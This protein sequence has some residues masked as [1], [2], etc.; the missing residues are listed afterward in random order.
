[1]ITKT[2]IY[3]ADSFWLDLITLSGPEINRLHGVFMK[4][5][6]LF[7][8]LLLPAASCL[9]EVSL[10][11]ILSSHMVV[12][13]DRPVHVWGHA[14]PGEEVRVSFRGESRSTK[15][16]SLGR[17]SLFLAPGSAGG[18]FV[19]TVQGSK[20]D[21]TAQ[22]VTLDDILVGDVWLASGQS[23]MQFELRNAST[24][25]QD[26]PKTGN[27]HIR[28]LN[29][30]QHTSD[31][32]LEDA[33]S[34]GWKPSSPDSAPSFSAI[35]WYFAREIEAHEH[36]PVGVINASW[37]GT[38]VESWVRLTALGEDASLMPLFISRGRLTETEGDYFLEHAQQQKQIAAAKAAGKPEPQFPWH[39]E[40]NTWAPGLIYN[41]M[42]APLT[43]FPLRGVIW[44]QGESNA[45]MDRAPLYHR[46]FRTLIEDWRRQWDEGNTPFYFV[47]L[48]NWKGG[49]DDG[50]PTL[51]EQQRKTLNVSNTAMAVTIDIGDADDI[52]PKDKLDVGLRLSLAA[53]ALS[54][55]EVIEYSGPLYRQSVQDGSAVRVWF[56]HARG[57]K[58]K[59][60]E[61][62]GFEVAGADGKFV[63]ATAKLEGD[64][65]LVSAAG[66]SAPV[67]VRYGWAGNP[68]CNLYNSDNLP[69]SPFSSVK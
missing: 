12:Q 34:G 59:G 24:A 5:R 19:L 55:G 51:R 17:W 27:D 48:A 36:V 64:S 33:P 26:L 20:A 2:F 15:A 40:L 6:S 66:V 32:A 68:Q 10:P 23:N 58:S 63:T 54:Y 69:A 41:G 25:A 44:Y 9:A 56:D 62:T 18:P 8:L 13:R 39:A 16:G 42:I 30:E 35:A 47:Q 57:L 53:R 7:L 11:K 52:H 3:R 29:I 50:W 22:I 49:A 28:L 4:I 61:L 60:G 45:G 46:I 38:P 1:M 31:Y 67:A 14:Q 65:V 43:P 37:G 21:G